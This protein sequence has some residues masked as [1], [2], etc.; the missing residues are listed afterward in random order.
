L[1]GVTVIG[2]LG[3]MPGIGGKKSAQAM[4]RRALHAMPQAKTML[5]RI[6]EP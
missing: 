1:S 2:H 6:A 3:Y 4:I 5:R